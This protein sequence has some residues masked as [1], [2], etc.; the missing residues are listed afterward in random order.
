MVVLSCFDLYRSKSFH[1]YSGYYYGP[2]S[3]FFHS[4]VYK[5]IFVKNNVKMTFRGWGV[6]TLDVS[7]LLTGHLDFTIYVRI[8][9]YVY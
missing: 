8:I 4:L 7:R 2:W 9:M 1:L 3:H 6:K 5:G